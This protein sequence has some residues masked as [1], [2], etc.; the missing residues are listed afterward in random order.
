M[1][2]CL[3]AGLHHWRREIEQVFSRVGKAKIWWIAER[4][5]KGG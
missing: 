4:F 1:N 5:A 2:I 3:N